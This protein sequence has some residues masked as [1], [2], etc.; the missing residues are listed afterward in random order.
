MTRTVE[1][2]DGDDFSPTLTVQTLVLR[3]KALPSFWQSLA[4]AKADD[5][6]EI[7]IGIALNSSAIYAFRKGKRILAIPLMAMIEQWLGAVAEQ[8]EKGEVNH[9]RTGS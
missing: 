3:E 2:K 4:T 1:A 9:A 8:E 5:G 6:E 7:N